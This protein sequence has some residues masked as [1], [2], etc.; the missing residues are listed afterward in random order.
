[1]EMVRSIGA[2]WVIDY[3]QEDFSRIG[4]RYDLLVDMVGNRSLSE[5]R[6]VLAP[7]GILVA[8]GGPSKG[9]WIGPMADWV[10]MAVVSQIVSQSMVFFMLKLNR[11]DLVMVNEFLEA[12]SVTPVVDRTYPLSD[13]AGAFRYFG[14][15]HA[16]G[17]VVITM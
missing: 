13:I 5:R 17:K 4:Q 6:R 3:T 2:D 11:E 9:R 12:G 15:G 10:K 8:V 1:V 16:K 14:T 7:K